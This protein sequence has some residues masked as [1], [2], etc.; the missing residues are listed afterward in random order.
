MEHRYLGK[1][2][3]RV[4]ELCLGTQTFGWCTEESEAFA[5]L[6]RFADAGGNF[7]DVAD[8]YNKGE[9]ERI[10]GRWLAK[11][12][13]RSSFVIATK[14]FFPTGDG[15]NDMGLSRK[16]LVE[17]V[18]GS[19]KRLQTDYV[20]I[21]QVHCW[22]SATPLEETLGTLADLIRAGKVCYVGVSNFAPS[23]LVKTIMLC[24]MYGWHEIASIQGEYS[25]AVR[26]PEWE[27]LPVCREEGVGFL[28]WSPL[29]GGWLTGK[30]RRGQPVPSDSRAGRRDRWEDL[31]EQ[32]ADE[33]LWRILEALGEVAA[34]RG[35]TLPQVALNWVLAQPGV[36]A[37][38][39]GARTLQQLEDNLGS[40]GWSLEGEDLELL[41]T[42]S[43]IPLPYPYDFIARYTR[44][45]H[46]QLRPR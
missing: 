35:K 7:C 20:D 1:T 10:L 39:F 42:V 43:A 29:A 2:G 45:R 5:M 33:R 40:V 46:S 21:Y 25:L 24:R 44:P 14:V 30:Y 23:H 13:R 22:D 27:L 28:P 26:S 18:E 3:L 4:S 32:R 36:V 17:A 34:R 37:P 12:G 15:P 41:N 31:T 8:S 38:I 11:R 6:D 9:S 16:H 19:L